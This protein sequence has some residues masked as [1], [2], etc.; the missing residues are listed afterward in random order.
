MLLDSA[1]RLLY[2]W[3]GFYNYARF[4]LSFG[5]PPRPLSDANEL[6]RLE[7]IAARGD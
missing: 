6:E 1:L 2:A 5:K 3:A 4:H 7:A